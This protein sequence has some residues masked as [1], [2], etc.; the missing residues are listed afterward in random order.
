MPG[1]WGHSVI[2]VGY[3]RSDSGYS[4][5]AA[6]PCLMLSI[7]AIPCLRRANQTVPSAEILTRE[8]EMI[9]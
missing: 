3:R 7:G 2:W 6:Q 1:T 8:E 5:I 4:R 9:G